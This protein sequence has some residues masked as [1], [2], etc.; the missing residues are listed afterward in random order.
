ML[1][2]R[3]VNKR[4]GQV[5]WPRAHP[6]EEELQ[7]PV[8]PDLNR[9]RD[10]VVATDVVETANL[11][12]PIPEIKVYE[13]LTNT[14]TNYAGYKR[15]NLDSPA[16]DG[17]Q[18]TFYLFPYDWRRDNIETVQL[19]SEKIARLKQK[20][21]RPNLKFNLLAHSMGGLVARY[22]LMYGEADVLDQEDARVT[23]AGAANIN[24]LILV[25]S[26]NEGTMEALRALVEG[27]PVA[28]SGLLPLFGRVEPSTA[29][30]MPAAFQLLPH[31][32]SQELYDGRLQP[33]SANLYEVET[34]RRYRWS[35]F[36]P[37]YRQALTKRMKKKFGLDWQ[38][39][40]DNSLVE[41]EAYLKVVLTRSRR[42]S[43][44]LDRKADLATIL[45]VFIFAG[46]CER[47]LRAALIIEEGGQIRTFFSPRKLR[48]KGN[49]L[50]PSQAEARMFEPGDGRITRRSALAISHDEALA[51]TVDRSNPTIS[52]F[53]C[54]IHGDLP[55]NLTFQDN[56]L[57]IFLK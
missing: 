41:R 21:Q 24:K 49:S 36:D 56:L 46:D 29:F 19:L 6:N 34:W 53:G 31:R 48:F 51:D 26:P 10:D 2:S 30:T 16:P 3:L 17:Y 33:I 27:F 23:W 54:E 55:N 8:S 13:D 47:T 44:A 15:G 5:V 42:F 12:F 11:G 18:D 32:G 9:N 25:G 4:T 20:L 57:S 50:M 14:L 22:Y 45:K 7:L 39:H 38:Q 1:G 35:I 40:F 43:E 37:S 52:I 28:E